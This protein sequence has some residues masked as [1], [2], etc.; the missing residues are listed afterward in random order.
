MFTD[1]MDAIFTD[2]CKLLEARFKGKILTTED[3]VRYTFFASMLYNNVEPDTV[4]LEFPHPNI[5]KAKIDTW[6]PNFHGNAVAIEFKY[7]RDPPGGK[8]QPKTQKAGSAFRDLRRLQLINTNPYAARYFVYVTTKKMDTYF[9]NPDNGHK[10]IYELPPCRSVNIKESYFSD[11]PKSFM[12]KLEEPFE[13]KITNALKSS[14][15]G[16]HFLRIYEV[17]SI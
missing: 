13:A 4:I 10:E 16:D 14:L 17:G 7:D 8:N 12:D 2:F 11:K 9:R 5:P 6:M 3:S 15:P 1:A